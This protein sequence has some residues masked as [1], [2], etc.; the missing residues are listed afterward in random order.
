MYKRPWRPKCDPLW[1]PGHRDFSRCPGGPVHYCFLCFFIE[2]FLSFSS[3]FLCVYVVVPFSAVIFLCHA[4][5]LCLFL[6]LP[7]SLCLSLFFYIFLI[8][9]LLFT[10]ASF[11]VPLS[12]SFFLFFSLFLCFPSYLFFAA[13]VDVLIVEYGSSSD[14]VWTNAWR[15]SH[16]LSLPLL[17]APVHIG[18]VHS[19][20]KHS[21]NSLCGLYN[22]CIVLRNN[23]CILLRNHHN[24]GYL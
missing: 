14:T 21:H 23:I 20:V 22:I 17:D 4:V 9:V 19:P 3:L 15:P 18:C 1:Q 13:Y 16:W 24:S 10:C 8:T 12:F 11:C 2:L 7:L 6:S 5:S